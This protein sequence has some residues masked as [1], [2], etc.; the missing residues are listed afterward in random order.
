[1]EDVQWSPDNP[2]LLTVTYKKGGAS[3]STEMK[4]TKRATGTPDGREDLFNASEFFQETIGGGMDA[5]AVAYASTQESMMASYKDL[6]P[7]ITPIRCV[8]KFRRV[9]G[10]EIQLV[11]RVEVYSFDGVNGSARDF[12]EAIRQ[13]SSGDPDKPITIYKYRVILRPEGAQLTNAEGIADDRGVS[14]TSTFKPL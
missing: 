6:A 5:T 13:R 9:S 3:I 7:R 2:N 14:P 10:P 8:S 11:Q 4:V 1:M 12:G